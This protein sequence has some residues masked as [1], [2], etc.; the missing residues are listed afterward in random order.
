MNLKDYKFD[1]F[2]SASV[3]LE[4]GTFT[5][6]MPNGI[7][8]GIGKFEYKNRNEVYIGEF[9]NGKR[10]GRGKIIKGY[11]VLCCEDIEK[12][13]LGEQ[14]NVFVYLDWE[15][16][17]NSSNVTEAKNVFSTKI[18]KYFNPITLMTENRYVAW[19][20]SEEYVEKEGDL[21]DK[22]GKKFIINLRTKTQK[23][24]ISERDLIIKVDLDN[25]KSEC[26]YCEEVSWSKESIEDFEIKYEE[27]SVQMRGAFPETEFEGN[28]FKCMPSKLNYTVKYI[29]NRVK[30][31]K[32]FFEIK[33]NCTLNN[34]Q[35]NGEI[36]ILLSGGETSCD[37]RNK[38]KYSFCDNAKL[39]A[40]YI[41]GKLNGEMK[42]SK[43]SKDII[44]IPDFLIQENGF[45]PLY[46]LTRKYFLDNNM[47][48][49][50]D[51]L[52]T[53]TSV[54]M[55]FKD[56]HA[57]GEIY[58]EKNNENGNN[59]GKFS[60]CFIKGMINGKTL[61]ENEDVLMYANYNNNKIM[62]VTRYHDKK[63]NKYIEGGISKLGKLHGEVFEY[64]G[65]E[66]SRFKGWYIEG[67]RSGVGF[68]V[69]LKGEVKNEKSRLVEYEI[70]M[71][72]W[73]NNKKQGIFNKISYRREIVYNEGEIEELDL[74]RTT[75]NPQ[76]NYYVDDMLKQEH[77]E[78]DV[79]TSTKVLQDLNAGLY[80]SYGEKIKELENINKHMDQIM[81]V[82][83][84]VEEVIEKELDTLIGLE[85]MK[86]EVNDAIAVT[87]I[88]KARKQKGYED[89]PLTRHYVFTGNPG[90]GKTTV[91][92]I[93]A[94]IFNKM[95]VLKSDKVVEVDRTQLVAEYVGQ[96]AVKTL[97]KLEEAKGGILF[98]DEAY[99]LAGKGEKDFGQEAID[100]ILKYMEDHRHEITIIV[101]GYPKEMK[102]FIDSNPGLKSRFSTYINFDDYNAHDLVEIFEMMAKS[103][104]WCMDKQYREVLINNFNLLVENKTKD[105]ANARL[106]RIILEK[107]IVNACLRYKNDEDYKTTSLD[108]LT[109]E[110]IQSAFVQYVDSDFE[111]YNLKDKIKGI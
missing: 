74:K 55:N 94:K 34:D 2:E 76:Y 62:G 7:I 77:D 104:K 58:C 83:E 68:E 50:T 69:T 63:N 111:Y 5:G 59:V 88:L 4:E 75:I 31:S 105:F 102:K 73:Q 23:Y 85:K 46:I 66:N 30:S 11:D 27:F 54:K 20:Y 90:T 25:N 106:A 21:F 92:R 87:E 8:E 79:N 64:N 84:T 43:D 51:E 42:F 35:L 56:G 49:Y 82:E 13:E 65:R 109:N 67:E 6:T 70:L 101:A 81:E 24:V 37:G 91:A 41:N 33:I 18:N 103:K 60:T 86:K 80:T 95:E 110:D 61:F 78:L 53:Y 99:T 98:I 108:L 44:I 97:E 52:K 38:N 29:T 32:R 14:T 47:K 1:N 93:L 3:K 26:F 96:T 16:M 9:K 72:N 36:D 71:G 48:D 28:Y 22:L 100:T 57:D 12:Y 40:I 45:Y 107:S 89:E 19:A 10:S 17:I 15:N 39:S